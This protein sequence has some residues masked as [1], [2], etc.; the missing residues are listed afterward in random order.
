MKYI[1]FQDQTGAVHFGIETA[2]G[3]AEVLNQDPIMGLKPTGRICK[4]RSLKAPL[5][6]TN[7][8]GIG[9]NYRQHALET[10]LS[11]PEHPVVFMKATSSVIGPNETIFLPRCQMKGPE[12]DYEVELA[13][14]L[15]KAAKDVSEKDALD[16]VF[17]YTV[18]NDVSARRWQKHGGGGQWTRGKTFDTFCPLGPRIITPDE[19]DDPQNLQIRSTLNSIEMQSSSTKDMIF[20]VAELIARLSRDTT[21]LPGTVIL[22]GTPQ[23]VGFARTPPVYLNPGDRIT[24][25]VSDIGAMTNPVDDAG[26]L[27][28]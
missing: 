16:Y 28:D 18:A 7:I 10:G 27:T 26:K 19:I 22:T 5:L 8:Y 4:I 23:G 21:L 11:I 3:N 6:P 17:G 20:S 1:R 9:L 13:V 15:G 25:E 12:V 14:I 2:D 24:V